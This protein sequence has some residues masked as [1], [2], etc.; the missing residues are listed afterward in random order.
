MNILT[1]K[2]Y[3]K[4]LS[5]DLNCS[6]AGDLTHIMTQLIYKIVRST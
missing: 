4:I 1:S 2:L 5:S 6:L 3:N